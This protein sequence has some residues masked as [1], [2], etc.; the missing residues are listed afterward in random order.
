[1]AN[2]AEVWSLRTLC[3]NALGALLLAAG[4]CSGHSS[5]ERGMN[6]FGSSV[7][8][9]LDGAQ[10]ESRTFDLPIDGIIDVDVDTFAGDVIVRGA[11]GAAGQA[12]VL[13]NVVA[14]HGRDR[15]DEATASLAQVEVD[16]HMERGGD[17]PTLKVKA[18][19][20]SKE[21]WLHRTDIE[22][23]LPELRR[24]AIRTRSGKV[25]IFENRGG[26]TV[27]TVD[28]EIRLITPWTIT[29][30]V[31]LVTRGAN[32][33]YRVNV[34]SCGLFDVDIVNGEVKARV[35]AG[36]WRILDRRNDHDTLYAQLG[37]CPNKIV[38]RT[39]DARVIVSVVKD[40]LSHGSWFLEP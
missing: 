4:G 8:Y 11:Q 26:A 15:K 1:M 38:M 30:N 28:G 19:T 20:A 21:P 7:T 9:S 31:T 25:F 13:V 29:D 18:T 27:H 36:D 12:Q 10:S 5:L 3:C 22:I 33:A 39:T 6:Q 14:V 40:P 2:V 17:V 37:T 34:G 16:A 23:L 32:I 35:E 24:A